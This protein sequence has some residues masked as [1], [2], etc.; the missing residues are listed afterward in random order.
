MREI[1][2]MFSENG[3]GQQIYQLSKIL[4]ADLADTVLSFSGA[5]DGAAKA[6]R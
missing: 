5:Q 4:N 3:E 2:E 6:V 1:Y